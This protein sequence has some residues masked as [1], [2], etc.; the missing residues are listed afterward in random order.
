MVANLEPTMLAAT[1]FKLDDMLQILTKGP[2]Y[3]SKVTQRAITV[4]DPIENKG[5]QFGLHRTEEERR[6]LLELLK[7]F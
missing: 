4:F 5:H 3:L 7:Q 1:S 2:E 6:A